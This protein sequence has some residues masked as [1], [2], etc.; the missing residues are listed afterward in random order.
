MFRPRL[1]SAMLPATLLIVF[2]G[3]S[4]QAHCEQSANWFADDGTPFS[5]LGPPRFV[6]WVA[7]NAPTGCQGPFESSN[8]AVDCVMPDYL[9]WLE[10]RWWRLPSV[11]FPGPDPKGDFRLIDPRTN[12]EIL[13]DRTRN[14]M[15][16]D[17]RGCTHLPYEA[18]AWHR[19][20]IPNFGC[21]AGSYPGNY[22]YPHSFPETF[23]LADRRITVRLD[24]GS[25]SWQF[26]Q[27]FA[28]C[29]RLNSTPP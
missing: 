14:Y 2:F 11:R 9:R 24:L 17:D 25:K 8:D 7:Q 4:W 19:D 16:H 23:P 10:A 21:P 15:V 27:K 26:S 22:Y 20:A 1:S 3:I 28:V 29:A 6:G 13:A 18:C 12:L 5:V